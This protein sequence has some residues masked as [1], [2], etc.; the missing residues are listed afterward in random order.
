MN[1]IS[2]EPSQYEPAAPPADPT[3]VAQRGELGDDTAKIDLSS[4]QRMLNS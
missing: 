1:T 2:T 4:M 3:G